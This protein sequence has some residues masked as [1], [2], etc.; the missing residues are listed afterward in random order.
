MLSKS[1][2]DLRELLSSI[3]RYRIFKVV[4]YILT[5]VVVGYY[6]VKKV[7]PKLEKL[8]VSKEDIFNKIEKGIKYSVNNSNNTYKRFCEEDT[9]LIYDIRNSSKTKLNDDL[10]N[11]TFLEDNNKIFETDFNKLVTDSYSKIS[12]IKEKV[13]SFNEE[14]IIRRKKEYSHLFKRSS[15]TLDDDQQTAIVTDEKH[16]LVVAGAGSGKTEV[17]ITRIAYLIQRKPDTIEANKILALAFQNKAAAE[18]RER[19]NSRYHVDVEIRTFHSLGQRILQDAMKQKSREMP[20]LMFGGDNFEGKYKT[21]ITYLFKKLQED[22]IMQN[23]I[24]NFMKFYGDDQIIKEKTDFKTKEEFYKY[25][26]GLTYRTLDGTEVK[27]EQE[28]EIM[29]FFITHNVNGNKIN[30]LYEEP[31]EWMKY[32]KED[33]EKIPS[34][35]FFFPDFKIYLEHWAIGKDGKVPEWFEGDNPTERYTYSM[36][37]KKEKFESQKEFLLMETTSGEFIDKNFNSNLKKKLLKALKEQNPNEDFSIESISY[38]KLVE[39]V[40]E[41]CREFIKS[42]SL[43]ISRFIVIAKTYS[44]EPDDIEKRLKSESWSKKQE[45]FAEIAIPIYKI[46]QEELKKGNF[47]DYSDMINLAV[48]EL[49]A[50]AN[51]YKDKYE[52]ILIDEYQDIS[53]QRYELVNELMKKNNKC[54]LFCVGDDWQSIMGFAGSN[55]DFF[56]NFERYFDHPARTDLTINYRSVKSIVETGAQIIKHNKD[57]QLV[58]KTIAKNGGDNPLSVYSSLH[59][60][61]YFE[62]YYRQIASHAIDKMREFLD[63]GYKPNDIMIL[64]RI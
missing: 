38:E 60:K 49:K 16:N 25:Q 39:R 53:T 59:Q 58:K 33:I 43:N 31:A 12:N 35:D 13:L 5:P 18:V 4:G 11:L 22:K 8:E 27:S 14:F 15:L 51:F 29:N 50:N 23:K 10:R 47:I 46:Y 62:Q 17:L 34:P 21:F 54:K 41:E 37:L 52:H 2:E 26:R 3:K 36:N 7:K 64:C 24:V 1:I 61:E 44:L 56:V 32:K 9:Y 6:I 20:Q 42:L 19:L 57:S 45:A 28:R 30:I 55:L 63:N 48:K 40:W